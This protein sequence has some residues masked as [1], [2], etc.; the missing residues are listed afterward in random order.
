MTKIYV[1]TVKTNVEIAQNKQKLQKKGGFW[2][3]HLYIHQKE[4]PT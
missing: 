4:R 1:Q 3:I 2:H